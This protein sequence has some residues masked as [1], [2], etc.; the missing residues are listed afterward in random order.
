[1]LPP[2]L[3]AIDAQY[4]NDLLYFMREAPMKVLDK[5]G[6]LVTFVP[7]KAQRYLH[8]KL[9][10]QLRLTGMV[11]ALILKGR[12][13]GCSLYMTA[14]NAHKTLRKP[15]T[16]AL[17]ISHQGI[18][19]G[20]LFAM[21]DRYVNHMDPRLRPEIGASN[22]NQLYFSALESRFTVGTA[23]N[24]DVG[25]SGTNQI[26]HWSETAYTDND[27]AI[28]DGAMQ[29]I[30]DLPGTEIVL[31]STANGP[32]GLFY[33]MCQEALHGRGNYQLIF[34]P[35]W[36]LDEYEAATSTYE[37]LE[38]EAAY[39]KENLSDYPPAVVERKIKWR[40]NKIYEFSAEGGLKAGLRK[41]RMIYPADPIEAFQASGDGLFEPGA[42]TAAQANIALTDEAAPLIMGIDSAGNGGGG[43]RT[44]ITLRRGRV[45]EEFIKVPKQQNMDMAVAGVA[46]RLIRERGVDMG[47]IDVGYGHGTYDRM[48]ELGFRNR[49]IGVSF[50]EGALRPDVYMNKR[51]EM[52]ITMAGWINGG[53]VRIPK[54]EE[55]H[56]DLAVIP[57]EQTTSD[58]KR[59]IVPKKDIKKVYNGK[60]T[61]Y[62]DSAALTFAYPV[63][64]S[65]SGAVGGAGSNN[66][67]W[68]KKNSGKSPL[69]SEN[70]F[71]R[72][73]K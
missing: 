18:A 22:R 23:G 34:I 72:G 35:W 49:V 57:Q 58:G 14:R 46:I 12:Q 32:R 51:S 30:P 47:F 65:V 53:D 4:T 2:E 52:I 70:F 61:D 68:V 21:V 42:I 29:T 45:I 54:N 31:E 41:F 59:Y 25:R 43:D 20:Q 33:T 5:Q 73:G 62:L 64:R 44:V 48:C 66:G 56:A 69:S 60:S 9:E 67:G 40:R 50:G 6:K 39:S 16:S 3:A 15:G 38:D 19:T 7:N 13:E 10:E 8:A 26:F 63:R 24:E 28:Q 71:R 37:A 27:L 11:R 36:W 17:L 55:F 1:M